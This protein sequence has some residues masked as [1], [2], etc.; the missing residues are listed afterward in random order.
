[1]PSQVIIGAL[2]VFHAVVVMGVGLY[3]P[4]PIAGPVRLI[5][6]ALVAG[7]VGAGMILTARRR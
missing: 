6:V 4:E 5:D 7:I 3:R 2:L 1:M